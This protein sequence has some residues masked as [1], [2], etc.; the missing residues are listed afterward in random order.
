MV[1]IN[2]IVAIKL[3]LLNTNLFRLIMFDVAVVGGNV[4]GATAAINAA[5]L[6]VNVVLIEKN[7][8]PLFPPRCG[9]ATDEITAE[10]LELDK[11]KCPKNQIKEITINIS[12]K[13]EYNFKV[14][15]H[16]IF[17]IDR[18]F[19]EKYLL[20]NAKQNGVD[21]KIGHRMIDYK[22]PNEII[23]DNNETLNG[24][25]IIDATGINCQIGKKIGMNV[26]LKP[27]DIGICIQSRVEG[28]FNEKIM[29]MWYHK[30]YA[31]F[32]YSWLFPKN[33]KL[34]NI[35]IGVPGGQ[36]L[37]LSDMLDNYIR[38][39][40]N[41]KFKILHTFNSCVPG[42]KPLKPLT[43]N[44]ILFVGDAARFAN[45][46]FENG[47]NNGVFSGSVAGIVAAKYIKGKIPTLAIYEKLMKNKVKR[48]NRAYSQKSKLTTE[49]KYIKSYTRAFSLV[50]HLNKLFP[51]LLQ[52]QLMRIVKKDKKIIDS[53]NSN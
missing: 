13:K 34:A 39:E 15:K 41:G 25:V 47:I 52:N 9:E 48:L 10:I 45:P 29:K 43:K 5:K 20:K 11:I 37:D 8:E 36:K 3:H 42:T 35:G 2:I 1:K 53:L 24:K 26:K 23:L 18:N 28:D 21:V 14:K 38:N 19:L 16:G 12:S 6:G 46:V 33:K 30:P 31:P 27:E 50:Y 44:N 32:G 51:N 40:T 4:S 7:K 49:E 22:P 17:I